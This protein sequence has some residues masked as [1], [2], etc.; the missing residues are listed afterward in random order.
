MY[1][2]EF[3]WY[4]GARRYGISLRV[5]NAIRSLVII[6]LNTRKRNSIHPSN[7]V[8]FVYYIN[9][10]AHNITETMLFKGN[11]SKRKGRR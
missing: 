3:E 8:Y 11:S 9:T 2:E 1:I 5:F 10:K 6:E 4:M 7:H